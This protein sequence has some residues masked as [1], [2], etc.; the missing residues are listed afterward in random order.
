LLLFDG[1]DRDLLQQEVRN[2]LRYYKGDLEGA[3]QDQHTPP[4]SF[5]AFL[6]RH[7]GSPFYS[8][9]ALTLAYLTVTKTA[10]RAI[11]E[12]LTGFGKADL[13]RVLTAW[14]Q[15]FANAFAIDSNLAQG[16]RVKAAGHPLSGGLDITAGFS[17]Q[18]QGFLRE[19]IPDIDRVFR[20]FAGVLCQASPN[21]AG[22]FID[23]NKLSLTVA[24]DEQRWYQCSHCA[25]V[26]PV[27]WWGHCP[28]CLASGVVAVNPGATD[29]LRA[30][31]AFF[32][33]PVVDVLEGKARPFNLSVE[34]HTAQLSYRDVDDPSTTTEDFERRFRDI[35]VGPTDTSIDV[36]SST[37][38][39]EVGI[40]I[41]S[42]VAVGLRN[43]PPLRQN[44]QQRA[45]R[46]GR[47][48]SAISTVVTYAQSSPHDNH[49]FENPEPII[50]GEPT[51]PG[52]DIGNPKIIERHIRAQLIQS[53]FHFENPIPGGSDIFSVLGKTL[54]FYGEAGTFI[55]HAFE[56]WLKTA[57][58]AKSCF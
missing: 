16:V 36:L 48:G 6:L 33:D 1:S 52:I 31:K 30:R 56:E 18:A 9:S 12:E 40:D 14:I 39:M 37:T 38:T 45:G 47:R 21:Y 10:Y 4:P 11:T 35:L 51:L 19:R 25:T 15:S 34:E 43:V 5:N 26:S 23:P 53:F 8:V 46:T 3:L 57:E 7:L 42:L 20:V 27:E 58:S 29:Y 32:R 28:A 50:A 22:Q 49:Y 55:F 24:T 13:D 2:Y 17:R 54:A 44:Y 41:G